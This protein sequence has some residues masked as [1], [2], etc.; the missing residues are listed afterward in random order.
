V[1]SALS[2]ALVQLE[3]HIQDIFGEVAAQPKLRSHKS[4]PRHRFR[5]SV[6]GIWRWLTKWFRSRKAGITTASI[7]NDERAS[8]E[9]K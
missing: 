6:V 5:V 4:Q 7:S 2:E 8:I 3:R 9:A 1:S